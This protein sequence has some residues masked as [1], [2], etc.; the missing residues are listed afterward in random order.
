MT[1]RRVWRDQRVDVLLAAVADLGMS[2][3][4]AAAGEL[5]DERVQFVAA[6]MRVSEPTARR[7][8][9]DEAVRGLAQSIAFSLV[10]ETPGADLFSVPRDAR[11]PVRLVGRVSAGLA[12]AVRLRLV[13]RD[14]LQHTRDAVAQ[15]AHGIGVVNLIVA[16]QIAE[17]IE[18]EPWV[19]VPAALLHRLARY[20]EAAASLADDGLV[21][22]S[23]DPAEM[24]GLSRALRDDAEIL[25]ALAG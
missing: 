10:E 21:G 13:E 4:R 19:R 11:I 18:G 3:S 2:M 17:D 9:T 1:A 20:L 25:R 7:Y 23:T 5:I 12:E 24:P 8:L 22:Y 15:L 6:Q 16:D 14:D